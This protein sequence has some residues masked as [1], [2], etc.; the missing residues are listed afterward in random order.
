MCASKDLGVL[1]SSRLIYVHVTVILRFWFSFVDLFF[2]YHDFR[3]SLITFGS[4]L[5]TDYI[6]FSNLSSYIDL[7]F[8]FLFW[9]L[10]F[11]LNS[12]AVIFIHYLILLAYIF[13]L[14][15]NKT[16]RLVTLYGLFY[17]A[18]ISRSKLNLVSKAFM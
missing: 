4:L 9:Y 10:T 15:D 11:I 18:Y 12:F 5:Y 3:I 14:S 7:C 8:G 6:Q 2:M 1:V 13:L 16:W 17:A